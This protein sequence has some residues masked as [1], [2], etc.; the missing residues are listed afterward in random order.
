MALRVTADIEWNDALGPV[1]E[2]AVAEASV[3]AAEQVAADA[4]R[5]V[6][7][8][9]GELQASI[10]AVKSKFKDGGAIIMAGSKKAFYAHMVEY[11]T[12]K[13]SARPFL[14]PALKKNKNKTKKTIE[15]AVRTAT[16]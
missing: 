16:R 13:K 6:P 3:K 15:E 11:G 4:R 10:R 7:V 14:R 5:L 9:S 2:K 8:N 12:V 1:I